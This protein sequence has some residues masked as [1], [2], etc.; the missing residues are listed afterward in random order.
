MSD[1]AKRDSTG[2]VSVDPHYTGSTDMD[3]CPRGTRVL[4][5]GKGGCL[6][7][8]KYSGPND[9]MHGFWTGWAHYPSFSD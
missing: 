1:E 7:V 6:T 5:R 9:P 3:A 2:T 4:L 8:G